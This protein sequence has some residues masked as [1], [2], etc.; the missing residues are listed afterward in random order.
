[1][2]CAG[3]A[4]AMNGYRVLCTDQE[5]RALTL[6]GENAR[7]NGV[8]H[9]VGTS[10]LD[11]R[12]DPPGRFALVLASDCTY[13]QRNVRP[14][15]LC[16]RKALMP[17]SAVPEEASGEERGHGSPG[18]A[19]LADPDRF[20]ARSL[21]WIAGEAGFTVSVQERQLAMPVHADSAPWLGPKGLDGAERTHVRMTVNIY[22]LKTT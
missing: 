21:R 11:W 17:A 20:S 2:G 14:L 7:R 8:G 1:M 16:I 5:E 4:A 10:L 18:V 3:I 15:V 6:T 13:E 22:S 9:L 19:L 12:D